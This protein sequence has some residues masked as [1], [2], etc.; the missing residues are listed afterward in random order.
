[1]YHHPAI[2]TVWLAKEAEAL[3]ANWRAGPYRDTL[4]ER[5]SETN[6]IYLLSK[7]K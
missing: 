4:K 6:P 7:L 2:K 5:L 1:M 3:V